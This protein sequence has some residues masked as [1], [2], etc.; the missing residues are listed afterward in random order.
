ME[1]LMRFEGQIEESNILK[2][3]SPK[4]QSSYIKVLGVGGAGT[5]AV[6]H[7]FKS[8]IQ[9]VDFIVCNTD[10]ASLDRS[11][12]SNKIKIGEGG[13]GAGNTPER[14]RIAAEEAEEEI[15]SYLEHN[16]RMLFVT[17]GMGGGTGTGASPVIARFAK[18]IKLESTDE[19]ILVVGVVTLPL[20]FEGRKRKT[21]AEEGIKKLKE[22]V[23]A[24]ITINTDKLREYGNFTM[25]RAFAMADDILLTAARGIS[26]MMT[27]TGHV[28]VDFRDVQS[29]MQNSGVALMGVGI[30]EGENRAIEAIQSATTSKLLNDNDISATKNI[31]LYFLSSEENEIRMEEIDTITT[32]LE[33]I[34][35]DDVDYIWGMGIDNSLGDKLSVTLVATGFESKRIYEPPTRDNNKEIIPLP[36]QTTEIPTGD[37]TLIRVD[38]PQ[39]K[40]QDK[41]PVEDKTL[42]APTQPENEGKTIIRVDNDMN[43]IDS[44]ST[45]SAPATSPKLTGII[46]EPTVTVIDTPINTP[47][48]PNQPISIPT[49]EVKNPQSEEIISSQPKVFPPMD[50]N[51]N[52][53]VEEK[54]ERIRMI[55]EMLSTDAGIDRIIASSPFEIE[56]Q[57]FSQAND[58]SNYS[59]N[60][61]GAVVYG[62]NKALDAQVD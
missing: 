56:Q 41:T 38:S 44:S 14:A 23:D 58:F 55:K 59:V 10:Q 7:M 57:N 31:L 13:L 60:K 24:I 12:V 18:E 4:E 17:A 34:T 33:T 36:P 8:G 20:S 25:S 29:V 21:Q 1:E 61:E 53:S 46:Q 3:D 48:I 47:L 27:G 5:N 26:E 40:V 30:A 35:N 39:M 45:T 42:P 16:T 2:M 32:Y 11:P 15:K 49:F 43:R 51:P 54:M 22:E 6:D 9:G 52:V 62:K 28:H 37:S 50:A 19:Q